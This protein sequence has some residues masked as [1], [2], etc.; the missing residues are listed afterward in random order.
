MLEN[1][2]KPHSNKDS[3]D[4]I[5]RSMCWEWKP[6]VTTIIESNDLNNLV[7]T[8]LFEKVTE[9]ETELKNVTEPL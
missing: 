5:L 2:G 7:I 8:K 3:A 4:K 6:K 9:H 1:F